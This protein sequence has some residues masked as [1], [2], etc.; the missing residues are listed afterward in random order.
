MAQSLFFTGIVMYMGV[1]MQLSISPTLTS[2]VPM[3]ELCYCNVS[4]VHMSCMYVCMMYIPC[5]C[6][7]I[8][9]CASKNLTIQ[10]V[11]ESNSIVCMVPCTQDDIIWFMCIMCVS[12]NA[13]NWC[14]G[15][16]SGWGSCVDGSQH[17][18]SSYWAELQGQVAFSIFIL[19]ATALSLPGCMFVT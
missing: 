13:N 11:H 17:M 16:D 12:S 1:H 10:T 7:Q 5:L 2:C 6:S 9:R 4:Y 3:W 14:W 19:L 8:S 18:L 15:S